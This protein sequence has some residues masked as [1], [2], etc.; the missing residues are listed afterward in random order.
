M[1]DKKYYVGVALFLIQ[2][3]EKRKEEEKHLVDSEG[4]SFLLERTA[5]YYFIILICFLASQGL[6]GL[7]QARRSGRRFPFSIFQRVFAEI[8]NRRFSRFAS[9]LTFNH[10]SLVAVLCIDK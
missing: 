5:P 3:K 7:F 6:Q 4:T 2:Q 10:L 1:T 8:L 9:S